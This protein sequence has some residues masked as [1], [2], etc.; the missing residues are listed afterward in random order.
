[1][2]SKV[3]ERLVIYA[4]ERGKT[5]KTQIFVEPRIKRLAFD[6]K[7]AHPSDVFLKVEAT[8]E[9]GSSASMKRKSK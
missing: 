6:Q 7:D 3:G 2:K 4:G 5:N 9:D 8:F 1:M